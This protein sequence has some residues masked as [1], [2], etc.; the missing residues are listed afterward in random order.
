LS[1]RNLIQKGVGG[2]L[3]MGGVALIE[4]QQKS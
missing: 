2:L 1:T 4:M 3:I